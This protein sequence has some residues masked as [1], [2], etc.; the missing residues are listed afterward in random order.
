[1][2]YTIIMRYVQRNHGQ[3]TEQRSAPFAEVLA[4]LGTDGGGLT[5][6]EAKRRHGEFGANILPEPPRPGVAAVMLEEVRNPILMILAIAAVIAMLVGERVDG[7]FILVALALTSGFGVAMAMRAER[8]L[9]GLRRL[10]RPTARAVRDGREVELPAEALV[11]GDRIVLARGMHIP[12]DARTLAAEALEVDESVLTGESL[13]VAKVG[14]G[15]TGVLWQ[16][17]TVVEG[18]AVAIVVATGTHT[19]LA[20]IAASL[21]SPREQT[22]LQVELGRFARTVA[23]IIAVLVLLLLGVGLLRG[24][25]LAEMIALSVAVGVAAI[26]EGLAVAVTTI[27]AIGSVHLARRRCLVRRLVA[28]ETLGS[29][30]VILTDKTGTLTEG[31]MRAT[32]VRTS[33][34]LAELPRDAARPSVERC[35][36]AAVLGTEVVVVNPDAPPAAW[37]FLGNST[38]AALVGAAG[39]SG[40]DVVA[41]RDGVVRVDRLPF[42]TERKYSV[43]MIER[44]SG[45]ITPPDPLLPQEGGHEREVILVGAPERIV[46]G[47]ALTAELR[48]E[49]DGLGGEGF[50]LVGVARADVADGVDRITALGDP[51]A[52]AELLG[53]VLLRDPLRPDAAVAL[54]EARAAGI[55][56]VMVTG[57]HPATARRIA[58]DLGLGHPRASLMSGAELAALS[59]AALAERI[60]TV[61]VFA[62]TTPDQ[63]LRLVEAWRNRGAV[64]AVTGDGVNDAPALVGADVGVAMGS[65]TDVAREASDLVLLDDRYE[66]IVA[67]IA[68]G[69]AIWDNLR[70]TTSYLLC[71]S[72]SEVILIGGALAIGMPIP[73]VPAQILWVNLVEDTFPAAAL[74]FEPIE[75]GAMREAPR[76]RTAPL[77]DRASRA[78]VFGVGLVSDIILLAVGYVAL[79]RTGDLALTRTIMFGGIGIN[80]LLFVFGIRSIREPLWRSRPFANPWLLGAVAL[81]A[82]LLVAG[83]SLPALRPLLRT[84]VLPWWGWSIIIGFGILELCAVEAMKALLR[85]GRR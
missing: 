69:R 48:G 19:K 62:R 4:M 55:R 84:T 76:A 13:P 54:A 25:R 6:A 70:K 12:A 47:S 11:P 42:S 44:R 49:L 43:T 2:R 75:P 65:G 60:A 72:F 59:D 9:A 85:R 36:A 45:D 73:L 14:D 34:G 15:A 53:I 71:S 68:G 56:T 81:S 32:A 64:V 17:T 10:V 31:R 8:A 83:L 66:T 46:A 57:D 67:G 52:H 61:D 5:S 58:A 78:L 39:V 20:A 40:I 77:F 23:A 3:P 27:L 38:E 7:A 22:P 18:S 24:E 74:A 80:S 28:A 41:V 26:P 50:R 37:E 82:V 79:T 51:T 29:V 33:D 30:S 16:G 35:L 21:G 1:M 63:K